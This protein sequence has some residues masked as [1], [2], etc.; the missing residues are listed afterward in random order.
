MITV[1]PKIDLLSL[2]KDEAA[3]ILGK[4]LLDVLMSTHQPTDGRLKV[5]GVDRVSGVITIQWEDMT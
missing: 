5:L 3:A 1:G 4:P 2:S